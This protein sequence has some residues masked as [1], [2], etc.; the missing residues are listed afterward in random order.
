MRKCNCVQAF[1]ITFTIFLC[2][3]DGF[4]GA[5]QWNSPPVRDEGLTV[6]IHSPSEGDV[7]YADVYDGMYGTVEG[8]DQ[9]QLW[10]FVRDRFNWFVQH[11]PSVVDRNRGTFRQG[12]VRLASAGQWEIHVCAASDQASRLLHTC[13]R[14]GQFAFSQLPPNVESL[15]YCTVERSFGP[16][17]DSKPTVP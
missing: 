5:V 10:V 7:I 9:M 14:Q 1:A 4:S 8:L 3:C 17:P 16:E 15:D 13:V 11:P 12:N 6:L 2:G